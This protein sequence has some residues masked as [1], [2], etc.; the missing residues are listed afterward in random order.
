MKQVLLLLVCTSPLFAQIEGG[1][2]DIA[3]TKP[4]IG[5][6]K[7]PANDTTLISIVKSGRGEEGLN[8]ALQQEYPVN[9]RDRRGRTALHWAAIEARPKE[10]IELLINH[11]ANIYAKDYQGNTPLHFAVKYDTNLLQRK[12][13]IDTLLFYGAD[14]YQ[15]NDDGY[16]PIDVAGDSVA[17]FEIRNML[18]KYY[19][20][21]SA[22]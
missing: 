11:G 17:D 19:L 15:R 18:L 16:S 4:R 7:P 6:P 22:Q 20:K 13:A 3:T 2:K 10:E 12:A 1:I 8:R 21:Q 5:L 14:I 9:A